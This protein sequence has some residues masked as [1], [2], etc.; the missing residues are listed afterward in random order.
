MRVMIV[1]LLAGLSMAGT[2]QAN[3]LAPLEPGEELPGGAAT[4]A[5]VINRD[6]FSHF[7]ANMS[8][9]K[10]MDFKVGNGFFRR[11][12]VTAPS[13]TKAADGLGPL[14]NARACQNCHLKDG[15]GHVPADGEEGVSLFLR[16]SIPPQ[17][18][19]Q[20]TAIAQGR[21]NIV[22]EPTYGGQL[23]NFAIAGHAAEGR[24]TIRYQEIPVA[25]SGG[26]KASL[27]QPSYAISD[28]GYGP[29]HPQTL[30][31]PRVAPP[32]IGLGLLEAIAED[33][34]I[35][36]AD[37]DDKD[38]DG[39]SG[40]AK[41]IWGQEEGKLMLGR[42]GWKGGNPT[43]K[44]Q[45]AD[46]FNGDIGLSNPLFPANSGDC[47]GAQKAC[48]DAPHGGDD[49]YAGFEVPTN[50]LDLVSFYSRNLAVP[51]RRDASDAQVLR[52]KQVFNQTGCASC[53]TPSHKTAQRADM[54]EQ[55]DQLIWP[56][57]DLL[58]H[59]LGDGLADNRPE[60]MA[61]GSEWKT[62]PLWGIGLTQVVSGH[63]Q[64]LHDGRARNT[65]EAIL[66]HGGEAQA[67]RDKVV[68]MPKADRAA[69]IRFVNS[70]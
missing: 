65:L 14:F 11:L 52:G 60:G 3:G 61:S 21:A 7:S 41:M 37:P 25:L 19:D 38:G 24:M 56:Y 51:K 1:S 8:F 36:H 68:S 30:I 2:A 45:S 15:R 35:A 39:I 17:S 58:L 42:F 22:P 33:S 59:D 44:Q 9:A 23:Q 64:L 50:V 67:A 40:R 32:M 18:E 13:S 4:H 26:E 53:H 57:T 66:W 46:A 55:S 5:K 29:L 54:P 31:S 70:L 20:K 34:L 48:L 12:W 63:T 69:L 49:Q 6:V 10:E 28:L 43:V 62:P 16:L 47:T 27:R